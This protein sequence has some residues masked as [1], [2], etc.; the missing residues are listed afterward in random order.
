MPINITI[1]W[2]K[3]IPLKHNVIKLTEKI[4]KIKIAHI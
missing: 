1:R 4:Q 2:N 3:Q